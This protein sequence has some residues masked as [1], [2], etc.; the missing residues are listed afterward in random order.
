MRRLYSS[1]GNDVTETDAIGDY[2]GHVIIYHTEKV[3]TNDWRQRINFQFIGPYTDERFGECVAISEHGNIVAISSPDNG[4]GLVYIFE[5]D[6]SGT[7][8]DWTQRGAPLTPGSSVDHF[9]RKIG[10]SADGSVIVIAADEMA[11]VYYTDLA[12][13]TGGYEILPFGTIDFSLIDG[14]AN[15]HDGVAINSNNLI[16]HGKDNGGEIVAVKVSLVLQ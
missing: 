3:H 4:N 1:S 14:V 9:G 6:D 15:F 8:F 13:E 16:V 12:D 7:S 5:R 11:F 10:L 2:H